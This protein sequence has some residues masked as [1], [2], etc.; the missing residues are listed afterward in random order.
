MKHLAKLQSHPTRAT[1]MKI[2]FNRNT[3][4]AVVYGAVTHAGL[5]MRH[6]YIEQGIAQ[7]QLFIRHIRAGTDQGTLLCIT[8]SWWQLVAG[9]SFPLLQYPDRHVLYLDDDWLTS[10]RRFLSFINGYL[11]MDSYDDRPQRCRANDCNILDIIIFDGPS[12]AN[13]AMTTRCRPWM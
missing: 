3:P 5:G 2:G 11:E 4:L 13:P 9:V 10:V 12:K 1:L 8:L 6:Q 7:L